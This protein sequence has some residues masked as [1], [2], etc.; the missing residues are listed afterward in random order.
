MMWI[1]RFMNRVT[2]FAVV[3]LFFVSL[4]ASVAKRGSVSGFVRCGGKGKA[5]DEVYDLNFRD[6]HWAEFEKNMNGEAPVGHRLQNAGHQRPRKGA[7]H[8]WRYIPADPKAV[9]TVEAKD[10]FGNV[11]ATFTTQAAK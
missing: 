5:T 1:K 9:I 6:W 7:P 8:T 2:I 11:I 3:A 4:S 10:V